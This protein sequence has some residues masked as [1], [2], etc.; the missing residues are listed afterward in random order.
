[1]QK[2]VRQGDP[3]SPLLFVLAADLLQSVVNDLLRK[4]HLSLPIPCHDTDFPI[5]QY[6][7]DTIMV[8]PAEPSQVL[9]LK[10]A[11]QNFTQSTGMD[12][13]YNKSSMI[14]INID[15]VTLDELASAFGC[16]VGKLPFT[17]LGLPV[18]TTRP[19][20][21]DLLP[22]VDC[23]ERRLTANSCFLTQGGKLQLLNF[24]ISSMPIYL[25][26]S[27]HIPAGIIKQL[28]RI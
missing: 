18:G 8:M 28:Q 16:Q 27:L 6:A 26:C 15:E 21:V 3:L 13:N 12:I 19:K 11:L 2:G 20:I 14:P 9:R 24:V 4:G 10:E 22:L 23:M 5:V 25:L 7:D 17:Y 1:M